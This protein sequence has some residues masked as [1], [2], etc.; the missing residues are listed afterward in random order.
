MSHK[1]FLND[2]LTVAKKGTNIHMYT[3]QEEAN[4]ARFRK[5]IRTKYPI[6]ITKTIKSGEYGPKM[7]RYCLDMKVTV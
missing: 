1:K 5:E 2:A 7:W 6:R 4:I 3:I